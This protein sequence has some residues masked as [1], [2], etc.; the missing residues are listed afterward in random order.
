MNKIDTLVDDYYSNQHLSDKSVSRILLKGKEKYRQ[1]K[2]QPYSLIAALFVGAFLS[3]FIGTFSQRKQ[4]LNE[5][6]AEVAKNHLKS[7]GISLAT[8]SYTEVSN[9]L[10]DLSF[11]F[12]S[13]SFLTEHTLIGGKYCSVQHEKAAQL[14]V[15][16]KDGTILTVYA[17]KPVG[18]LQH[19]KGNHQYN[20]DVQ[21]SFHHEKDLLWIIAQKD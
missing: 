20:K 17:V 4:F 1:K 7:E 5:T 3:I 21:I 18:A 2:R 19:L 12:D 14:K 13:P 6:L 15:K 8:N 9:Y 11:R 16:K 10:S